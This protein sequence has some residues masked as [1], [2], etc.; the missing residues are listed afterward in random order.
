[1]EAAE[2]G[3]D[4]AVGL[5]EAEDAGAVVLDG[6]RRVG[7]EVQVGAGRM[8][9]RPLLHLVEVLLDAVRGA[10]LA[11]LEARAAAHRHREASF[12]APLRRLGERQHGVALV[13]RAD[14]L[15][16]RVPGDEQPV[17]RVRVED[18][19]RPDRLGG[20]LLLHGTGGRD[21]AHGFP[22]LSRD[23]NDSSPDRRPRASGDGDRGAS[24]SE[25]GVQAGTGA[26]RGGLGADR[27]GRPPA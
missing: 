17:E 20:T 13:V 4:Q 10:R 7:M 24:G 22:P 3:H 23:G 15:L 26:E 11:V 6:A 27:G 12:V 21:A 16:H 1:M 19:D 5:R 25:S 18:V 14:R 8:R 9:R 2:L